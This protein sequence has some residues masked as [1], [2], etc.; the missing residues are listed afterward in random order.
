[1]YVK[2][3]PM[4]YNASQYLRPGMRKAAVHSYT[5]DKSAQ[6]QT[7]GG[8][9]EGF[10]GQLGSTVMDGLRAVDDSTQA[11]A[12][13]H[14]LRLPKDGKRLEPDEFLHGP[15][16]QLGTF[17]FA[18]RKDYEGDN[19]IYRGTGTLNDNIG[20]GAARALQGGAVVGLTAAGLGLAEMTTQFG[21]AADYQEPNQLSL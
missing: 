2:S 12:R 16:N 11:F 7:Q 15:R 18:A 8:D 17:V 21:S 5:P 10:F 14:L 4:S 13:D 3:S 9:E 19:T 6:A 1:M 20:L